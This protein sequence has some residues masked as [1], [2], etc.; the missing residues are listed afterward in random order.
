MNKQIKYISFSSLFAA[1]IFVITRFIQI[2]IPLGYLNFG[3]CIILL[4]CCLLPCRYA[5]A[6][7][8]L[9]SAI[10]D[11]TSFPLYTVPTL[12]IKSVFP[13]VFFAM[14]KV[15]IKNDYARHITAAAVSTLIPLVG[16]TVTGMILY[17]GFAAGTAQI[18]G[19]V[20]E[21]AANLIIFSIM[22]TQT[23]KRNIKL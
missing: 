15:K 5:V 9:G 1:L 16:Y 12:I 10:A 20:T 7:S 4:C 21:Y 8:A 3:N 13:L 17:G 2:P 6:A 14:L 22:L 11:L 23:V 18:P 19:L